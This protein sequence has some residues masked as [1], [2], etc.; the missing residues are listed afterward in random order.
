MEKRQIR[1]GDVKVTEKV[2][3]EILKLLDNN[4]LSES[5]YV[6]K[7]EQ[8][9]SEEI[10]AKYCI[11]LNSGTSALIVALLCLK[12]LCPKEILKNKKYVVTNALSFVSDPNTIKIAGFEPI[13]VD[14]DLNTF[15]MN[16][17]Y[18]INIIKKYKDEIFAILPVHLMGYKTPGIEILRKDSYTIPI[19][20]D[21]CE[22]L[23]TKYNNKFLGTFSDLSC[24]SFYVTHHISGGEMG[25]IVT[26]NPKI[27]FLAR[28]IKCHGRICNCPYS[29][30][31]SKNCNHYYE[32]YKHGFTEN[33]DID[34]RYFHD[35]V[36]YNFKTTELNA[37]IVNS[38]LENTSLDLL[39]IIR[40]HIHFALKKELFD[41][42]EF[43][44]LPETIEGTSYFGF[45]IIIKENVPFTR[46]QFR[47]F[48][49]EN[50]IETRPIFMSLNKF[51]IF[52]SCISTDLKVSDMISKQGVYIG[53]HQY[54]TK[55]DI[56]YVGF[57]FQKF[58]KE[59]K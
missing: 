31:R 1:I 23:G 25:C 9:F 45:A 14:T 21:V 33:D 35:I 42:S 6:R 18:L 26:D 59:R 46:K 28:K 29:V 24:Y 50:G 47:S 30:D 44:K 12:E 13:F 52:K 16:Y 43:L 54:L 4:R 15:G 17:E 56:E 32:A 40:E 3:N 53:G 39:R 19:I 41:F 55:E 57:I 37:C 11:A 48:L 36:G 51:P 10:G 5:E 8:K 22:S 20:E 34:T 27:D 2:K 7:F 58:F 49:E 38:Q